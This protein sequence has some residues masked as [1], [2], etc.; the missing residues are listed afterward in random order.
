MNSTE[1]HPVPDQHGVN[2]FDTDPD[3]GRVLSLYLPRAGASAPAAAPAAAG[4]HWP[5][6]CST[7]W[8]RRPT[9]TRRELLQR[10]RS[11]VD[12]QRIVKH[13]AYVEMERVAFSQYGLAAMSHRGGVLGWDAPLPAAAKYAL[14]Y[15]FVQAEFGLCCPLSMTDSLT[16]TLRKFGAPELVERY[17]PQLTTQDFDD[18]EPGRDVHDRTRR[19]LRR[20]RHRDARRARRRRLSACTATSGSAPTP[21]P[22][23][24]WCWRA[25]TVRRPA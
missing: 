14:T 4:R 1:I 9:R 25:S 20:G 7:R 17:L 2:L 21:M 13:P 3:L 10:T 19:R 16:R 15:L 11:G 24:R 12:A 23:W 8:R 6:A 22:T 5:A 18:A